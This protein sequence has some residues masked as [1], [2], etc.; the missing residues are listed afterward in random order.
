MANVSTIIQLISAV[1]AAATTIVL[2]FLTRRYVKLTGEMVSEMRLSRDPSVYVDLEFL[3]DHEGRLVIGNSGLSPA[4]NTRFH[5]EEI[6]PW[7]TL[8][9]KEIMVIKKGINL[10]IPERR[11]IYGVEGWDW[12]KIQKDGGVV[13]IKVTFE[14]EN[15]KKFE[16]KFSFDLSQYEDIHFESFRNPVKDMAAS[17]KKLANKY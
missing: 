12:D 13:K 3:S 17:L 8:K 6:I 16:N 7:G 4:K 2:A 14:N 1:V 10:L 5:V 11:L 9:L 15:G